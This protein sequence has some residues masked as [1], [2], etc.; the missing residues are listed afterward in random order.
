MIHKTMTIATAMGYETDCPWLKKDYCGLCGAYWYGKDA[1]RVLKP[2][3]TNIDELSSNH[4]CC[5]C[6]SILNDSRSRKSFIVIGNKFQNIQRKEIW[7]ILIDPPSEPFFFLP[8]ISG[9]K[10][11]FWRQDIATN[12]ETFRLQCEQLGGIYRR[13][14]WLEAMS[15]ARDLILAAVNRERL[16][17]KSYNSTDY[18]KG[19]I[20]KINRFEHL[21]KNNRCSDVCK[22]VIGLMPGKDDLGGMTQWID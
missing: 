4:V 18:Q 1:D 13:S 10:H 9:K 22:I 6:E 7:P 19:G 16:E 3:F 20:D 15:I 5:A 21:I 8:T 14:E 12:K 11:A 17:T 2:T